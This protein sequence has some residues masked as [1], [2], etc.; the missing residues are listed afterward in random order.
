MET[1]MKNIKMTKIER[2]M[3]GSIY[4]GTDKEMVKNR[5]SGKEIDLSPEAVAIYDVILG[6]EVTLTNSYDKSTEDLFYAA[7]DVF[8]KNWPDEYMTLVD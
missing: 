5:F 7:R 8:L 4:V 2:E 3:L 1:T 6:C